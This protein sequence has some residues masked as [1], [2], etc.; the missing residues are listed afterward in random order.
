MFLPYKSYDAEQSYAILSH[1]PQ[2]DIES[3]LDELQ[4]EGSI[5]IL[6]HRNGSALRP[7]AGSRG[8]SYSDR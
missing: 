6:R 4:T 3:A 7:V 8:Y 5:S 1:F 2:K